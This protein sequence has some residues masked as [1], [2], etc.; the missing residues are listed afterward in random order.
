M[1][2]LYLFYSLQACI[3][4]VGYLLIFVIVNLLKSQALLSTDSRI[5]FVGIIRCCLQYEFEYVCVCVGS[6]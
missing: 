3:D 5:S 4:T 6:H 2:T 1:G